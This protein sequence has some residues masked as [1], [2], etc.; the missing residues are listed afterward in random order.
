MIKKYAHFIL[1][2]TFVFFFEIRIYA[3]FTERVENN[4]SFYFDAICFK[5]T[6][7]SIGRVDVY[8]LVPYSSLNFIKSED[9]YGAEYD[10]IIKAFD[11][12]RKKIDEKRI[13]RKLTE[14]DYFTVNGGTGKFDYSQIPL[15]I[16]PGTY[17]IEA[18]LTDNYSTNT[19]QHSRRMTVINYSAYK[20]TLSGIL[21]VS[22]IEDKSGKKVITPHISDNVGDLNDGYFIFFEFYNNVKL[23]SADFIYEFI[24]TNGD[25][26]EKS[27]IFR[28]F[29]NKPVSQNFIRIPYN[30]KIKSGVYTL[31]L[32]A[33][34]AT[35]PQNED[36]SEYLAISERSIKIYHTISGS[37]LNDLNKAIRQLRY[38]TDQSD[39]DYI[40]SGVT[41]DE[42]QKRFAEFWRKLDPTPNTDRNEAFDEYYA[43]IEYANKEFKSYTEGWLTDK[44]MVYII[45]GRPMNVDASISN[46]SM[47]R[48]YEV[49][50]YAG[51]RQFTFADNSG[52][53][54]FRLISP[55]AVTEKY[56]YQGH[57]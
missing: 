14:T 10:L 9:I 39:I 34:K 49:W 11:T 57:N 29:I 30:D 20:C 56:K 42:K 51:N 25:V 50:T 15:N 46:N 31:R 36:K 2:I 4:T 55:V 44:G 33:L 13:H 35:N 22:S 28:K 47:N 40:E 3:Q 1:F 24:T 18:I 8:T 38:V 43:R 5:S 54:D 26:V 52:F 7:D 16:A 48:R 17:D 21:L 32:I 41:Q 6:I 12:T 23:D 19:Y 45:F 27:N 37:T 53:G